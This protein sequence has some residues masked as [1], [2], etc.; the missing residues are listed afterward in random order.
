MSLPNLNTENKVLHCFPLNCSEGSQNLSQILGIEEE[1]RK[2]LPY[3]QFSGP[4][5]F[6][7]LLS[8]AMEVCKNMKI[9]QKE[10]MILL[11]LTDGICHDKEN[12]LNELIK[13]YELPLSVIVVGIGNGDVDWSPY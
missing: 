8:Q 1:Y 3:L 2:C 6:S 5:Y 4:T 10:Y 13:C 12:F 9:E 11:I 7:S